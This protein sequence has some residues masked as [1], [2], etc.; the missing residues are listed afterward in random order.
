VIATQSP[1]AETPTHPATIAK[2]RWRN[3]LPSPTG[4]LSPCTGDL[5]GSLLYSPLPLVT[6]PYSNRPTGIQQVISFKK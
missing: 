5:G 3:R 6:S 4:R 1:I 2:S